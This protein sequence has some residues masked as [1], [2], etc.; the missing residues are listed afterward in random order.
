MVTFNRNDVCLRAELVYVS[1]QNVKN[2]CSS[3][4]HRANKLSDA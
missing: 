3:N 2:C 4:E 1:L